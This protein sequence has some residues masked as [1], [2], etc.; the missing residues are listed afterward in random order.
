M[1]PAAAAEFGAEAARQIR[2]C[3]HDTLIVDCNAVSPDTVRAIARAV[4]AAGGRF[5]DAGIIGAPPRA[6]TGTT[7]LYVSGPEADALQQLAGPQLAIHKV[8]DRIGDASALKMCSAALTKGTQALWLEI[9]I[10]ARRLGIAELLEQEVRGGARA[11]ILDWSLQQF[12]ILAPKAYRWVPEMREIGSTLA[13]AGM[14]P[15][16]FE[17]VGEIFDFVARTPLGKASVETN[18]KRGLSGVEVV[19]D[20][21]GNI[22]DPA[23]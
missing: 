15:K 5:V 17:G 22:V 12:S 9:L 10:A 21:A 11:P 4:T 14:T 7:A 2:A 19:R 1:N 8:S 18:R 23:A 16:V 6:G 13:A 20:L 3:G